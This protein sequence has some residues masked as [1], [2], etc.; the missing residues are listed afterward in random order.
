MHQS[1]SGQ[2]IYVFIICCTPQTRSSCLQQIFTSLYRSE[3]SMQALVASW[4]EGFLEVGRAMA[5]PG[6][7]DGEDSGRGCTRSGN[8]YR[9]QTYQPFHSK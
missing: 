4:L 1:F 2:A 9:L 6:L 8:L 3:K 7:E 5:R